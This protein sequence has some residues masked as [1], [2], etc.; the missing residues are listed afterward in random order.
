M[1]SKDLWLLIEKY[2]A[3]VLLDVAEPQTWF[4]CP[5]TYY[6]YS[7]ICFILTDIDPFDIF[8]RQSASSWFIIIPG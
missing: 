6:N 4:M 1:F 5:F 7:N 3:V 2:C 8:L